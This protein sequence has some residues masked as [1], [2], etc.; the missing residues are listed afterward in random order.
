MK[1]WLKSAII[2]TLLWLSVALISYLYLLTKL[3]MRQLGLSENIAI[4]IIGTPMN[5]VFYYFFPSVVNKIVYLPHQTALIISGAINLPFI[6]IIGATIGLI[7]RKIKITK[8]KEK[9]K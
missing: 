3:P 7:I 9:V 4:I 5:L 1:T 6:I 8:K 2:F